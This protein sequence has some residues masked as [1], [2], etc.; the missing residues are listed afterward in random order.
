[1]M[2]APDRLAAALA[3]QYG[4]IP[5]VREVALGG[6]R[7]TGFADEDSDIDL[8]VYS[9]E[10]V[11]LYAR[12]RI[13]RG[14]GTRVELDNRTWEP[15]DEWIEADGT[16]VDVMFRSAG[17]IEEQLA[18][19]LD[20]HEASTG[21]STCFWA[22]VRFSR[23]LF[24]RDG[25]FARLQDKADAPYPDGLRSAIIRKNHRILRGTLSCYCHQIAKAIERDDPVSV[26]HRLAALL[27]SYFDILFALNRVPHPG[28]KRLLRWA[29]ER[30]PVR[31][32][33]CIE[34][35]GSVLAACGQPSTLLPR[36]GALL[37]GLDAMLEREGLYEPDS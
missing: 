8:Y 20:R 4:A 12:A 5:Q 32:D 3:L 1:M 27:A 11:P 36:V 26:N 25:W 31:P 2:P 10:S 14:R 34:Q 37:D 15:G 17:W 21:Y 22:N 30:C 16:H 28:E 19:V 9:S 7:S 24:D 23:V 35:V 33:R 13:A 6:S 29:E 18:R